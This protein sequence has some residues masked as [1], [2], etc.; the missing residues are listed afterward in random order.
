MTKEI[1]WLTADSRKF[2]KAGYLKDGVTA[3]ARMRQIAEYAEKILSYPGFADKFESYLHKGWYSLSSPVWANFGAGR[4]LPISCF[5]SYIEDN[6][7]EILYKSGEVGMMS[8]MAGGTSGYFGD[9]RPRGSPISTG[10]KSNGVM[11]FLEIYETITNVISQSNVRRGSF[12]AYLPIE[13]GDILEFLEIKEV[14]CSIQNISI[15][16]TVTDAWMKAMEEGDKEKQSLWRKVLEKKRK[17]G[18]P[19][20]VFIDNVN[21][22]SPQVYKD[23][24]KKIVAQNLCAEI[25]LSSSK[26][27]SFVC[28]LSSMNLLHYDEWKDTDAV[29][30]MTYFL[31]SVMSDFIDKTSGVRFFEAANN[32]A[33]N[34]RALGLGV[35]GWHS[36]LQSKSIAFESMEAKLLNTQV[37]RLIRD[38]SHAA[39]REMAQKYGEPDLLKGYG[40]RNVTT[41]AIAPTASSSI[42]LGHVS[43]GIEPYLSN[44]FVDDSAKGKFTFRNK[45]LEK[46]LI[47]YNK[48]DKPTWDSILISGGS[49]Q[50]LSFLSD[51]EKAV[52][53]CF[54]EI[55]Q[56]EIA[57]QAAARQKYI[58][59]GQSLNFRINSNVSIKD[60]N[61]L[62]MFCWKQGIKSV[63]YQ[64]GTNPAQELARDINSC[65]SCEA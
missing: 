1:K 37:H 59:Q 49:V 23:K 40:M 56:K 36:L 51:S 28:C 27:E 42:I 5:G 22:Q 48:N 44:Y 60:M 46:L 39:S 10:G 62:Y 65:K 34:Q 25:S 2:L 3:E 21:N 26:D 29:E 35:L 12:A 20:I 18:Y 6:T 47:K 63:Y 9:I 33:K 61:A 45:H 30:T 17:S 4:G 43:P 8:K 52:Y 50:H 13:H 57:I 31:D 53:K 24:G 54:D 19:Y 41:M 11:P 55:S 64:R 16:I 15:G 7:S 14:K 32:F 58:D 38:R